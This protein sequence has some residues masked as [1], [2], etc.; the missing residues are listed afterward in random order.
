MK[1]LPFGEAAL[2]VELEQRIAIDVAARAAAIADSWERRGAGT[3][4]PAY[5][6]VVLR[7]DPLALDASEAERIAREV[8]QDADTGTAGSIPR[9][10]RIP[11][12]YDGPDLAEVAELSSLDPAEVVAIHA[13]GRYRAYF[14]G[15]MPGWAYLGPLDGRLR[16]PRRPVPR[17]R[18][19]AGSVAVIDGQTGVYPYDSPGGWR[20]IGRTDI[21]LFDPGADP[22]SLIRPGDTVRFV[23]S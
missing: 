3:A 17:A 6:S 4:I 14:V 10:V 21:K 7:F 1:L 8:L 5:A 18:V 19:P 13:A 2:F 9:E 20:L 22:P 11:T 12:R 16:A 23:P 15:F